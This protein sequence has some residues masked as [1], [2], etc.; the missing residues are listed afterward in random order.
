MHYSTCNHWRWLH[1]KLDIEIISKLFQCF[2]FTQNHVWNWNKIISA[3]G[4]VLEVFQNYFSNNEQAEKYSWAATSLR[5]N[6]EI[7][8]GKFPRAEIQSFQTDVDDGQNNFEIILF[9]T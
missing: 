8:S 5:N 9:H 6:F 7:I 2:C 3:A 4:G 1:V